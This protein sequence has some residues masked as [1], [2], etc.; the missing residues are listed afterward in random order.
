MLLG[1]LAIVLPPAAIIPVHGMVQLGSNAN[2]TL[3]TLRHVN[4][5]TIAWFLPGVI[6]GA[7]LASLFLVELPLPLI[8][9]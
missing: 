5:V 6:L 3:M 9:L 1:L 4:L 8:Q 2:R 7:W